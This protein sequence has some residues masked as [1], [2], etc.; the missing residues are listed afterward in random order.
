[1]SEQSITTRD[2]TLPTA[3]P[4]AVEGL[5]GLDQGDLIIPRLSIV[6]P[7]SDV[8]TDGDVPPG[9]FYDNLS[10]EYYEELKIVPLRFGRGRLLYRDGDDKPACKSDDGLVPS[11]YIDE[12]CYDTCAKMISNRLTAVCSEAT[13]DKDGTPPACQ[14]TYDLFA[15]NLDQDES[16]FILTLK[17]KNYR[18]GKRLISYFSLRRRSPYSTSL[19]LKTTKEKNQ[20]GTFFVTEFSNYELVKP[21]DKYRQHFLGLRNYDVQKTYDVEDAAAMEDND[22]DENDNTA[23]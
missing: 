8:A 22:V 23:F 6:Q 10:G 19:R 4:D 18:S 7:T 21:T 3:P 20:Y 9:S 14:A 13:W 11:Q 2:N 12:P 1:M 17:G 15:L 5:E 16:P